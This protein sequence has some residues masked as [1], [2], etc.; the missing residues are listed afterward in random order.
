MI[1][2]ESNL[3]IIFLG[4]EN[5]IRIG[6]LSA[7]HKVEHELLTKSV[8]LPKYIAHP[9]NYCLLIKFSF[10]SLFYAL[11]GTV[12]MCQTKVIAVQ[13]FC[14]VKRGYQNVKY[15]RKGF[16]HNL[17][18]RNIEMVSTSKFF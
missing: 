6:I 13:I 17:N 9:T 4:I 3:Y 8:N 5:G 12:H 16:L 7:I 14:V 1:R 10:Y 18:F 15:A 2:L 11:I